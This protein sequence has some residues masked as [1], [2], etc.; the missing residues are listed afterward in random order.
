VRNPKVRIEDMLEAIQRINKYTVRGKAA[1][2]SEELIQTYV[3]HNLQ[4]LGEAVCKLTP[5]YRKQHSEI[6]WNKVMG[7]RH[8]LVHDYFQVDLEIVWMV[9][10]KELPKLKE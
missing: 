6:P 4:I 8:I 2:A 9:V 5:E 3:V 7:M 1:F 10:E